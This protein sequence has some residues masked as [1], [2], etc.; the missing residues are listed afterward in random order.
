MEKEMLCVGNQHRI[1]SAMK[2]P[3]CLLS[4]KVTFGCTLCFQ[5]AKFTFRLRFTVN[6]AVKTYCITKALV[7]VE[8]VIIIK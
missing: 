1:C 6:R 3:V 4:L 5:S 2:L 7:H 8:I